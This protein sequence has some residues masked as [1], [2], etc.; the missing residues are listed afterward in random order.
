MSLPSKLYLNLR[1]NFNFRGFNES[2]K[3]GCLN[4]ETLCYANTNN[5][6]VLVLKILHRNLIESL[7][8]QHITCSANENNSLLLF[9]LNIIEKS[10]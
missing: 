9:N 5:L 3:A 2:L 6:L 8:A 7:H 10:R 1:L 4:Y